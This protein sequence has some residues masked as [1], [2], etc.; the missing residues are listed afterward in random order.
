MCILCILHSLKKLTVQ[1]RTQHSWD[2]KH[3]LKTPHARHS[4]SLSVFIYGK[5]TTTTISGGVS[6]TTRSTT[7]LHSERRK[8]KRTTTNWKRKSKR[9]TTYW[10]RR[11]SN[12]AAN[13]P[14]CKVTSVR[15]PENISARIW[16]SKL[17]PNK[18][19]FSK[20]PIKWSLEQKNCSWE[21]IIKCLS[22]DFE[23]DQDFFKVKNFI[24]IFMAK[25]WLIPHLI[26]IEQLFRIPTGHIY[27][28]NVTKKFYFFF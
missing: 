12:F 11:R 23:S 24:C 27:W 15:S 14:H 3:L 1:R 8:S 20:Y 21:I 16:V 7:C 9:T 6:A 19:K 10:K 18:T 28:L 4:L 5:L 2:L 26:L 17:S 25:I 22:Y 13:T